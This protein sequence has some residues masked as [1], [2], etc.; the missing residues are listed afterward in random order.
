MVKQITTTLEQAQKL[1]ADH[2]RRMAELAN[3]HEEHGMRRRIER[4]DAKAYQFML[5]FIPPQFHWPCLELGAASGRHFPLL[6]GWTGNKVRGVEI[7]EEMAAIGRQRGFNIKTAPLEDT[8]LPDHS[9]N[10]IVSR[11]V[12]EHT[13][14]VD[15]ALAEI[16]RLLR[17]GGYVAQATPHYF[18]DPEP[19]HICQLDIA[20]WIAAFEEA[21]FVIDTAYLTHFMCQECHVI[22]HKEGL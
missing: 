7:I 22:A 19:A 2:H 1:N 3:Q 8:G 10:C 14:D 20:D 6:Q 5:K 16:K 15:V 21:G 13:Y 17:P 9:F 18:P 11:H 4:M 12:M